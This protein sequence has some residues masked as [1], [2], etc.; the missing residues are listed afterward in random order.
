[1]SQ[2]FGFT[3]LVVADLEKA[4]QFYSQVGELKELAR[5]DSEI[6]GKPISE[7]MY[8]ATKPGG[9]TFV[10]LSFVEEA[11]PTSG[12]VILGFE[13]NDVEAFVKRAAAAGASVVEEAHEM[14]E[15]GVKVAFLRDLEGNLIE[16]VQLLGGAWQQ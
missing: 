2:H 1:M 13:T 7:I 5:V 12:G 6:G 9:A 4:A 15:H 3:K 10:L 16:V 8:H 11:A 14:P